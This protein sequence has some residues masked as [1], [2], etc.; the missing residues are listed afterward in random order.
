[1]YV[2]VM[3]FAWKIMACWYS[4][5]FPYILSVVTKS[6]IEL[7]F[8]FSKY[9]ILHLVHSRK[10][11]TYLFLQF[12]LWLIWNVLIVW[13]LLKVVVFAT[14]SQHKV[15]LLAK[16]GAHLPCTLFIKFLLTLPFL[17]NL[18]PIKSL[19]SPAES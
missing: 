13:L 16:H 8:S 6:N 1:M 17:I 15:L 19:K 7:N 9:C 11:I 14:F 3:V 12:K 10:Y 5:W 2:E 4:I 18:V